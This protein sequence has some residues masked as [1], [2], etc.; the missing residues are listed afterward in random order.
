[1]G[2]TDRDQQRQSLLFLFIVQPTTYY[3]KVKERKKNKQN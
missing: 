2:Q 1:M 3:K